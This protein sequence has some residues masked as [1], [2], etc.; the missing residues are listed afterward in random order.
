METNEFR[1][2][3]YEQYE[4]NLCDFICC[5]RSN[6][7]THLR[8][9][10]HILRSTMSPP[11]IAPYY[12]CDCGKKYKHMSSLHKHRRH[13]I[14]VPNADT[15]NVIVRAEPFDSTKTILEFMQQSKDMQNFFIE[16]NRELQ[17][18]IIELSQ[19]QA[20]TNIHNNTITNNNQFNIN[21]FLNEHCKDAISIT[22]FV[23]S[24]KLNVKDLETTG[25][26]GFI[27]GISRIFIN[28]LRELD[29]HVRPLHCT[30]LK[31]ETVYIKDQFKWEKETDDKPRLKNMI[32]R[33]AK[34]NLEQLPA[35]QEQ[36]PNFVTLDTKENDDF[37]K[38]SLSSLGSSSK[39]EE[40]RDFGKIMRN[41][42]KEVVVE[43]P[44]KKMAQIT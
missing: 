7:L 42:L 33:I 10:K 5:K 9:K 37:L 16:Q 6:W 17:N 23:N 14:V 21:V 20:I 31:R 13:C 11:S 26:L 34:K 18:T 35:W 44:H 40:D 22:D 2:A 29:L 24:I 39:E 41:V 8:T 1:A 43:R 28:K 32:R 12:I 15:D 38:I 30:D 25:N 27:L 4:C 36:N 19:K 3:A